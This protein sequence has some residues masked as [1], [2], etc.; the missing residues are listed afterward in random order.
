M[1]DLLKVI[2]ALICACFFF[3]GTFKLL[4]VMQQSGYKG[5]AF[6]KWLVKKENTYYL[7]LIVWTFLLVCS[8][9]VIT[10]CFAFV[11]TQV[12]LCLSAIPF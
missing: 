4:G 12:V 7:R 10:L 5:K 2:A 8:A 9:A 3:V 6:C 11:G 1:F